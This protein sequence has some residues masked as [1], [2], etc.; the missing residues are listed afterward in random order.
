MKK[1]DENVVVLKL[2]ED[3]PQEIQ[4]KIKIAYWHGCSDGMAAAKEPKNKVHRR[5]GNV[6]Y[7]KDQIL[8]LGKPKKLR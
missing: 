5:K 1:L 7:L 4:N 8:F 3:Q 2:C 6:I